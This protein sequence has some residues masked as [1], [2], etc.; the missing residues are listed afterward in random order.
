MLIGAA[1]ALQL[2]FWPS[3][4]GAALSFGRLRPVH[5]NAILFAF[6]GNMAF[7][8]IV[9]SS[10]RLLKTRLPSGAISSIHFWGWQV[11]IGI[12]LVSI[13]LGLTQ[14][15][16]YAE[17][18]WPFDVAIALLWLA[19]CINFIALVAR[20][21][22]ARLPVPIWFFIATL[23]AFGALHAV[24]NFAIPVGL[25]DSIPIAGGVSDAIIHWWYG[26][27]A[28]SFLMT[29][30]VL[31]IMYYV[32]P[33]AANAPI[34]SE[35][36]A[37]IHFWSLAFL[38]AWAGPHHLLN[39]ALPDWL[40]T[41]GVVFSILLFAPSWA[42]ALNGLLT[43][44]GTWDRLRQEPVLKFL[45]V[46]LVFYS[47]VSLEGPLLSL[48]SISATVHFTDWIDGH[49][50]ASGFGWNGFMAAGLFYWLV[51]RL[52]NT[53]LHS[54]RAANLHF[55]LACLGIFLYVSSMWIAGATQG[56]MWQA[57][58][59]EGGLAYPAFVETMAGL[60]V[61]YWTRLLGGCLYLAGFAVMAWNLAATMR[62]G[63]T[64][65]HEETVADEEPSSTSRRWRLLLGM[66]VSV[67]IVVFSLTVLATRVS[68]GGA[69][70]LLMV[71][72]LIAVFAAGL[73]PG[74]DARGA[75]WHRALSANSAVFDV[76]VVA[77]VAAGSATEIVAALEREPDG[78][79]QAI[80]TELELAGRE[81]YL[82]E[83]CH[84]CHTQMVRPFLW[85]TA[86]YPSAPSVAG[87]SRYD[88]PFQWGSKRM[89]PDLARLGGKYPHSWHLE[90]M[91]DPRTTS[92]GSNMPKYSHLARESV[93]L[94]RL[95]AKLAALKSRGL[96]VATLS[97]S[98]QS[99]RLTVELAAELEGMPGQVPRADSKLIA[100]IAYLQKL[101]TPPQV[102]D[103]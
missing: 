50:H 6:I 15:K 41:L 46:A 1:L 18:E 23:V 11:V 84:N 53:S 73:E 97:T 21:R 68:P 22:V 26:H 101:G 62:K 60:G 31:G 102:T 71:A 89:G 94:E 76:L 16:E 40:Q 90:H 51:P 3:N 44:R 13:P 63:R 59:A 43:L 82:E 47:L 32:V 88:Y 20:R 100:L 19:F 81:I 92:P 74:T 52:W 54:I 24:G 80:Y 66:P 12:G 93:D 70:A 5:T 96:P 10:Q 85:E 57:S 17:L 39:S 72:S 48:R 28:I 36:L 79:E 98:D 8:G 67:T 61:I 69:L 95:D 49:A 77:A 38:Y 30:P 86:R 65:E 9:Y 64:D 29:M 7:A 14:G 87:E 58:T 37:A 56:A 4:Q 55:V 35:R 27:N 25:T 91:L 2:S 103:E 34:F 45:A 42:G 83:G 99:E 75:S 33:R 78:G